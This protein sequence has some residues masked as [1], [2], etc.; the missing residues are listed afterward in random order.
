MSDDFAVLLFFFGISVTA[1]IALAAGLLSSR[2]RVRR[3]EERIL[4]HNH[5]DRTDRLEQVVEGLTVQIDQITSAQEFLSRVIT[6]RL[7]KPHGVVPK[8]VTPR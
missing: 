5:D 8:V 7:E 2:R 4:N 1:N 3:L 6:N